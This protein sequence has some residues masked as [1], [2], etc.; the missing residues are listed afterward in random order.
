MSYKYSVV[1]MFVFY[2]K[3]ANKPPGK[4]ANERV[5]KGDFSVLKNYDDWR[6]KLSNFWMCEFVIDGVTWRSVE[7]YYQASK[8]K[9]GNTA[10]FEKIRSCETPHEAKKL[11]G[12]RNK[13][14]D[15]FF[16]S[17]RCDE[18]MYKA[19]Y[20]KFTQND[21]LR[22]ILKSTGDVELWH[23]MRGGKLVRFVGLEKIRGYIS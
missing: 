13:C 1:V 16:T 2:S 20:A 10:L 9:N 18:E 15:D 7:H 12:K 22:E 23:Y 17:G 4:G 14:D 8:F 3:S 5:C 19:Q 21:E 11:G 6:K